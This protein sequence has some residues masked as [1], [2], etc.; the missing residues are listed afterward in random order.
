MDEDHV[1]VILY[2]SLCALNYL[3][4][5]NIVHRDLKPGN[6]LMNS[7]CMIKICDFGLSRNSSLKSKYD[8]ELYNV[9]K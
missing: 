8:K 9:K 2:N 1:K 4:S 6:L 5:A 7:D 3:H